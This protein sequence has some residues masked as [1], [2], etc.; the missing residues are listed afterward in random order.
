[1]EISGR[2]FNEDLIFLKSDEIVYNKEVLPFW[3][4]L[5]PVLIMAALVLGIKEG[6]RVLDAGEVKVWVTF[7]GF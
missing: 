6:L 5:I 4:L 1:M 7:F 2:F 3:R